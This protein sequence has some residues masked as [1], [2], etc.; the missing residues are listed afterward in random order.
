[1][2][3]VSTNEYQCFSDAK[4]LAFLLEHAYFAA[5]AASGTWRRACAI[6]ILMLY[7]NPS[8]DKIFFHELLVVNTSVRIVWHRR[9]ANSYLQRPA[10]CSWLWTLSLFRSY[11]LLFVV[12]QCRENPV[13]WLLL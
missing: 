13:P 2:A 8:I 1:M 11:N 3:V 10:R 9:E 4:K 6:C 12:Q 7:F 5:M